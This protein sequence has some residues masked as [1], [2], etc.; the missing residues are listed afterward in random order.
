MSRRELFADPAYFPLFFA[1]YFPEYIK[2]PFAD[3]HFRMFADTKRLLSG[4]IRELAWIMF[5][6]SAKTSIAK[7]LIVYLIC[8]AQRRYINVDSYDKGNAEN[9]LFDVA[10]ALMTN[11]AIIGDY[12]QLYTKSRKQDEMTMRRLSKFITHNKIMAEAHSTSESV[13]GRL[14]KDQRPDFVL[15][16]DFETN[17]TKDSKAYIDQVQ[18]PM[19]S[20]SLKD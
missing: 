18:K 3:F 10:D 2:Y 11:R 12:G 5:R 8:T 9:I 15:L 20:L 17:K 4:A 14:H 7:A 19:R 13:R 1:Y 16:D 6:E